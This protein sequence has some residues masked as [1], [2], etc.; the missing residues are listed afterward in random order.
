MTT[1][2]SAVSQSTSSPRD[3]EIKNFSSGYQDPSGYSLVTPTAGSTSSPDYAKSSESSFT[4]GRSRETKWINGSCSHNRDSSTAQSSKLRA[5]R[6]REPSPSLDRDPGPLRL[7][8][9]QKSIPGRFNLVTDDIPEP[10]T[11]YGSRVNNGYPFPSQWDQSSRTRPNLSYQAG[12]GSQPGPSAPHSTVPAHQYHSRQENQLP[13]SPLPSPETSPVRA[14]HPVPLSPPISPAVSCHGSPQP[15]QTPLPQSPLPHHP[16]VNNRQ[17]HEAS[18]LGRSYT[19][20]PASPLFNQS[21]IGTINGQPCPPSQ[22]P[23]NPICR[24]HSETIEFHAHDRP[25]DLRARGRSRSHASHQSLSAVGESSS[26][27]GRRA[28]SILKNPSQQQS[29]KHAKK[30]ESQDRNAR[31]G[32]T[33]NPQSNERRRS[34]HPP[35][36]E[37]HRPGVVQQLHPAYDTCAACHLADFLKYVAYVIEDGR[38]RDAEWGLARAAMTLVVNYKLGDEAEREAITSAWEKR[39]YASVAEKG[40]GMLKGMGW[41]WGCGRGFCGAAGVVG[42]DC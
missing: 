39:K 11:H 35:S 20:R 9:P 34:R 25:C 10:E 17:V 32:K 29:E 28:K 1:I 30:Q 37:V 38:R 27:P 13:P 21:H 12:W 26:E 33:S 14:Y 31:V 40:L 5:R 18:P 42:N 41:Y 3:G 16:S 19:I 2:V 6:E 36:H 15:F 22:L 4:R 8:E 7:E 23:I 24:V